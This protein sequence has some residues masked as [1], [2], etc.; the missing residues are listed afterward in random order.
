[1]ADKAADMAQ[2]M[3]RNAR[4]PA[5][6]G[7]LLLGGA[8]LAGY[9]LYNSFYTGTYEA[10]FACIFVLLAVEG[11]HRAI[12]F[13]RLT[14]IQPDIYREGLHFRVPWFQYPI[15]Y[16]I[17]ARP[18]QLRSPTGSKGANVTFLHGFMELFMCRLANGEHWFACTVA[19]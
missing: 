8:T 19:A 2:K 6:G 13:N 10:F 17:R 14:G 18:N 9:T 7:V 4:G 15:I 5:T 1:M 12:I 3:M 16:D 11:G